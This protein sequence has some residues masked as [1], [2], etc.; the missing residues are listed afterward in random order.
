MAF[1]GAENRT[2]REVR[3]MFTKNLFVPKG[4]MGGEP[5]YSV[6]VVLD[7]TNQAHMTQLKQLLADA[8]QVMEKVWPNEASRPRVT[9]YGNTWENAIKDGDVATNKEKIP[10]IE[11][12]PELAGHWFIQPKNKKAPLVLDLG[13]HPLTETEVYSGCFC[14]VG[15]N[16]F[17]YDMQTA[18][19][20]T[21]R[22][23]T[24]G[25]NG[26]QKVR[27]GDRIGGGSYSADDMFGDA[28]AEGADDPTNYGA[29][30]DPFATGGGSPV[31]DDDDLPF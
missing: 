8:K 6:M 14:N 30:G 24:I 29:G 2:L 20:G 22:G 27:E 16:V 26:V 15:V 3:V 5:K 7:K 18:K 13:H 23:V 12:N 4:F 10:Y 1:E 28:Q 31:D 21:V 11:K 19:G 9:L 25:L 17:A